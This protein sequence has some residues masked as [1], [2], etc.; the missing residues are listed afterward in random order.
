M[1][2]KVRPFSTPKYNYCQAG[3]PIFDDDS[4]VSGH[5]WI[6]FLQELCVGLLKRIKIC[7]SLN[8]AVVAGTDEKY[9][10]KTNRRRIRK[11]DCGRNP[12]PLI[13]S[14]LPFH[15]TVFKIV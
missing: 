2:R 11:C 8:R 12:I 14:S 10:R 3:E 5:G 9:A 15:E 1:A 13:R 6:N 7:F 4:R